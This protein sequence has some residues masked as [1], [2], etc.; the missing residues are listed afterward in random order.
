MNRHRKA[1]YIMRKE[2]LHQMDIAK[3]IKIFIKEEVSKLANSPLAS[4][5][6]FEEVITEVLPF[7]DAAL[8]RLFDA[9]TKDFQKVLLQEATEMYQAK[10]SAFGQEIMRKVERDIY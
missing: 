6:I 9:D 2:I 1:T 5:D 4:S 7:D 10:E 3:R 8:D